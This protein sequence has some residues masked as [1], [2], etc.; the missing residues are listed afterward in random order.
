MKAGGSICSVGHTQTQ[1]RKAL[2]QV[3]GDA[4][5]RTQPCQLPAHVLHIREKIVNVAE[6]PLE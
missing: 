1:Q 2:Q 5:I 3:R 6:L 4:K